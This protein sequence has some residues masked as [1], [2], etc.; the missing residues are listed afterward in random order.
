MPQSD[1]QIYDIFSS[2]II[3]VTL[4]PKHQPASAR[5]KVNLNRLYWPTWATQ[6]VLSLRSLLPQPLPYNKPDPTKLEWSTSQ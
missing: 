2:T 6:R 1:M 5:P 3:A 4:S